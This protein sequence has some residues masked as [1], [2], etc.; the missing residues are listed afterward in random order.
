[1]ATMEVILPAYLFLGFAL[2]AGA[3]ALIFLIGGPLAAGLV[4]SFPLTA[5]VF[6]ILSLAAW[7]ILRRVLGVREGQIKVWDR[8]INED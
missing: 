4:A 7:L 6:A 5:L 2:G 1:M 3:M 8:D